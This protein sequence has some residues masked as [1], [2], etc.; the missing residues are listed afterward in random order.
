[1]KFLVRRLDQALRLWEDTC[2][3]ALLSGHCTIFRLG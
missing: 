2:F 1:M 3:M